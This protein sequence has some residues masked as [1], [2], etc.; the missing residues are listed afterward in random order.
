MQRNLPWGVSNI[1]LSLNL[2]RSSRGCLKI[3]LHLW[4]HVLEILHCRTIIDE[5]AFKV[6]QLREVVIQEILNFKL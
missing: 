6:I 4:L 3:L 5:F 2:T 1:S